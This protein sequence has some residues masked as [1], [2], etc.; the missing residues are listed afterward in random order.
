MSVSCDVPAG[1]CSVMLSVWHHGA[2]GLG[3]PYKGLF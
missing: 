1:L 2:L 3:A